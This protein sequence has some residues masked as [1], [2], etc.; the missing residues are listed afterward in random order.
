MTDKY[1]FIN[2]IEFSNPA[3]IRHSKE[4]RQE[5]QK[6]VLY[7]SVKFALLYTSNTSVTFIVHA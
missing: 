6:H 1:K 3:V 7:T 5:N 2:F 4:L